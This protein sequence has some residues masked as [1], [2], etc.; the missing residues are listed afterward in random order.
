[1]L[2]T[3]STRSNNVLYYYTQNE[4]DEKRCKREE[5]EQ[6]FVV[7]FAFVPRALNL[8]RFLCVSQSHPRLRR[9]LP[10]HRTGTFPPVRYRSAIVGAFRKIQVAIV[11]VRLV[12]RVDWITR[13]VF[14]RLR[15]WQGGCVLRDSRA[16]GDIER[17]RRLFSR[18]GVFAD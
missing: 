15:W 12:T 16:V 18:R 13:S 17:T 4:D 10:N 3:F 6:N 7:A 9:D 11:F 1:M 8:S 2:L 5:R 14:T